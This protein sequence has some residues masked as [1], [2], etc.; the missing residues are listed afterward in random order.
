MHHSVAIL[1]C[2]GFCANGGAF[3][4]RGLMGNCYFGLH[5]TVT[6]YESQVNVMQCWPNFSWIL[7]TNVTEK[8]M[9]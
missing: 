8:I 6:L 1:G 9:Q 4:F 5:V 7:L 3:L 2:F